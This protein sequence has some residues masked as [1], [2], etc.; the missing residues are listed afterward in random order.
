M[1]Q[2]TQVTFSA[3]TRFIMTQ[4]GR[5]FAV[6]DAE[7]DRRYYHESALKLTQDSKAIWMD[8]HRLLLNHDDKVV[9]FDY[10]GIN[11]QS[12]VPIVAGTI[13]FFDRSYTR[14]YTIAP[15]ANEPAK[16]SLTRTDL[17]LNL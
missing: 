11:Q 7:A 13:P 14:L 4:S 2:P 6:Y 10:D 8:G 5:K 3:N 16:A 1:S 9:V 12:L 17:K 15:V